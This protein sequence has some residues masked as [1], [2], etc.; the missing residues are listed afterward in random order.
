MLHLLLSTIKHILKNS[1]RRKVNYVYTNTYHFCDFL[2]IL[3]VPDFLLELFP[4]C[5]KFPF[6]NSETMSVGN[7]FF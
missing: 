4:F 7:E 6:S 5:L 2:F 1:R 3:D